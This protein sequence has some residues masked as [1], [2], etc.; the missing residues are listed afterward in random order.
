M[1]RFSEILLIPNCLRLTLPLQAFLMEEMISKF[2]KRSEDAHR[3]SSCNLLSPLSLYCHDVN[4]SLE[5]IWLKVVYPNFSTRKYINSVS[6]FC[7]LVSL[8]HKVQ[9]CFKVSASTTRSTSL[10]P[11]S[12][13][14]SFKV[15]GP[16]GTKPLYS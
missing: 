13:L 2:S 6:T 3:V 4:L 5:H 8:W 16:R 1:L 11:F 10:L 14:K 12:F 15:I 7:Q 9:A